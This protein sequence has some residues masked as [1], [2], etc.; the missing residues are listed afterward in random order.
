MPR[1]EIPQRMMGGLASTD[2]AIEL[3]GRL[4]GDVGLVLELETHLLSLKKVL[5]EHLG[6]PSKQDSPLNS[7]L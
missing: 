6:K 2:L 4:L 3:S 7:V 1:S 5:S